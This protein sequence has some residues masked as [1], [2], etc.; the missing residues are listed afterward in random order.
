[1]TVIAHIPAATGAELYH[2]VQE[3]YAHQMQLLDDGRVDEWALT[4][5]PDGVFAANAHPEP[6][7]GREAI[8]AAARKA[9]AAMDEQGIRRRHWLGMVSVRES[10][11]GSATARCYALVIEIPR[12]GQAVVRLSTVCEDRL[13]LSEAGWQVQYRQ[14]NRDDLV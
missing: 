14:V 13:V 1:M 5:T 12:G 8:S 3:F 10:G 9:H 6:S 7:T 2:Q 11:P 4:F